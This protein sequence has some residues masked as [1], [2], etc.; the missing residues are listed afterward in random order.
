M[1]TSRGIRE[2]LKQIIEQNG[3]E[4]LLDSMR[5]NSLLADYH[6]KL[7]KER[8]AIKSALTQGAG[9]AFCEFVRLGDKSS[10]E[11]RTRNFKRELIEIAWMSEEAADFAM[12]AF[13]YATGL[14]Q[15]KAQ[16]SKTTISNQN[17]SATQD[18]NTNQNNQTS[19]NRNVNQGNSVFPN[20]NA[21]QGNSASQ[22]R[23]VNQGNA[24]SSNAHTNQ[25]NGTPSN[26]TAY[27]PS[28]VSSSGGTYKSSVAPTG[29]GKKNGK[30]LWI[31][32]V[33]VALLGFGALCIHDVNTYVLK[34][35]IAE[36]NEISLTM[37]ESVMIDVDKFPNTS[38]TE[39]YCSVSFEDEY[40]SAGEYIWAKDYVS[41]TWNGSGVTISTESVD[42]PDGV[43]DAI[44]T[45]YGAN[46]VEE[47]IEVTLQNSQEG[48][49]YLEL[50]WYEQAG[51]ETDDY[52]YMD[53]LIAEYSFL[54]C[55]NLYIDFMLL[56]NEN[57]VGEEFVVT[58]W[59]SEQ[60]AWIDLAY[61]TCGEL[62][63][64]VSI[65]CT[66]MGGMDITAIAFLSTNE[67]INESLDACIFI[68]SY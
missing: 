17:H 27:Q 37:G 8:N 68:Y 34:N 67:S 16:V 60:E 48:D 55:T 41:A 39:I 64:V 22:N 3:I 20:G 6:P 45:V 31:A 66:D 65:E 1:D 61:I 36:T 56:E 25:S 42:L 24:A 7:K 18:K 52:Y 15:E 13:L 40:T 38:K 50:W 29:T 59:D 57:Y 14:S 33:F 43:D 53:W 5:I 47:Y 19:P 28:S 46:G 12:D 49:G 32:V 51:Y 58:V 4:C 63:E 23:S 2:T 35:L 62:D 54:D 10:L 9:K 26:R 11:M 21:N 30:K 44:V